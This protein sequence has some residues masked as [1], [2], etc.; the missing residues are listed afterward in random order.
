MRQLSADDA[1]FLY[2]DTEHANANVTLVLIY[3]PSGAPDGRLQFKG[4]LEHVASRLHR[5]PLFRNRLMRVPLGLDVPYW[6]ED[7]RFDLEYHVRHIAL[8]E[9][10]D[11]RQFCIQASRI[12]ARP[13]D[14]TRPLWE[15]YLVD[16]LDAFDALPRNSFALLLKL[17]HAAL[18]GSEGADVAML[19]HDLTPQSPPPAP[20]E[21]WFPASE[22]ATTEVLLRALRHNLGSPLLGPRPIARALTQLA[23]RLIGMVSDAFR[24]PENYPSARFNAEVSPHR[25]F[26]T[27]R[28]EVQQFEQIRRLVRGATVDDVVLTVCGGALRRYLEFHEELPADSLVALTP[29]SIHGTIAGPEDWEAALRRVTLATDVASPV[30]RLRVIQR[31]TALLRRAEPPQP[32]TGGAPRRPEHAPAAVLAMAARALSAA[33]PAAGRGVTI[34]NCTIVNAP[35]PSQ[36]LYLKGARMTYFSAL[37]PVADGLGLTIAVTTYEGRI[38]VSPTACREQLPDPEFFAKCIR[39]EFEAFLLLSSRRRAPPPR[40]A[41][42]RRDAGS[43]AAT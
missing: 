37:T 36:A 27:R 7:E 38:L 16:R 26:D 30:A 42:R 28:F 17:H 12:H 8:P 22:P 13:L 24:H 33:A 35:G 40:R 11:W 3:D 1:T 34:A 15:L 25:V 31:A 43:P 23:P 32:E 21:P 18:H 6:V 39:E 41:T 9:P 14:L 2:A 5:A 29:P 10:G 20:P 4:L 19:L